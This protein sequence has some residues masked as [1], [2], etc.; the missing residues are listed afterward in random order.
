M[1]PQSV[2]HRGARGRASLRLAYRAGPASDI[3][4]CAPGPW[5]IGCISVN[6]NG[7]H[8]HSARQ[9]GG[10]AG[11]GSGAAGCDAG[12]WIPPSLFG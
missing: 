10:V 2:Q 7:A 5:G 6:G 1:K 9:R 11:R 4:R 12:D 8:Y 3:L